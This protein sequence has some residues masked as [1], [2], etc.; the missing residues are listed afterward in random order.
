MAQK[1]ILIIEDNAINLRLTKAVVVKHGYNALTATDAERALKILKE[2]HPDL[3]L[4]DLQLPGMDGLQLT[5]FL[6][7]NPATKNIIIL[8]LTAFVMKGDEAKALNAGCDG[9]VPKPIDV[10]TL[11]IIIDSYLDNK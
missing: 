3:I 10:R 5:R 6:K 7:K 9:Y 11:P 2:F 4:M 8:A 1:T